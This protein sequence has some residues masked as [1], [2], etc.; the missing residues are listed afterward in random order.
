[1]V[2][3][4]SGFRDHDWDSSY[5]DDRAPPWDL[6]RPQPVFVELADTG[7]ITSPVLDSGCGTGEH[8]LLLAERGHEVLGVDI[9]PRAID[10]AK[11][12]AAKRGIEATFIVGDVLALPDL[13]RRFAS[14]IDCGVFHVFDDEERGRY[15]TS[16][17]AAVEA[18]GVLHLLCM[19][20]LTPG[21][22]G[23]RRV[24]QAELAAAFQDGWKVDEI[25]PA[26]FDVSG[27]WWFEP[28]HAWLARI[29]RT[30]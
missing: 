7:V 19:S 22:V 10:Q 4:N 23:P 6:G 18:A 12:K 30:G 16:L 29:T 17:A 11:E 3:G 14:V 21:D 20:E 28:P 26:R 1:M 2:P 27:D 9:S 25:R 8:A 15:V 5:Q 24:T 13:G